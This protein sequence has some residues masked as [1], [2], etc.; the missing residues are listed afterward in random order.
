LEV[1]DF[2][3]RAGEEKNVVS[4]EEGGKKTLLCHSEIHE[5]REF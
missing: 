3:G 1:S 2:V 5:M 4:S